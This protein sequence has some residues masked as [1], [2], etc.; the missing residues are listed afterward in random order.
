MK[1]VGVTAAM[2]RAAAA[3]KARRRHR[4][5]AD[6][7]FLRYVAAEL[8]QRLAERKRVEQKALERERAER[9]ALQR[10]TSVQTVYRMSEE[11][12]PS[13]RR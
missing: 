1:S 12:P 7:E 13:A 8:L 6:Y 9:E 2:T 4:G 10:P 11:M 5:N 3:E